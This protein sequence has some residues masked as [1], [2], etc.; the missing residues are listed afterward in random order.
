VLPEEFRGGVGC[1]S[2]LAGMLRAEQ[3]ED[4]FEPGE[5]FLLNLKLLEGAIIAEAQRGRKPL[6]RS[7][8]FSMVCRLP[9]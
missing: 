7:S 2:A 3:A 4:A 5:V 8:A 1:R 9:A 6:N